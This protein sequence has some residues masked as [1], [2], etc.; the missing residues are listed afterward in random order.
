MG[1][2]GPVKMKMSLR[3]YLRMQLPAQKPP[4]SPPA[5]RTHAGSMWRRQMHSVGSA[6]R[7]GHCYIHVVAN[8]VSATALLPPLK[9]RSD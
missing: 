2:A 8:Q 6:I 7:H 1:R 9:L 4:A 3:G 5:D